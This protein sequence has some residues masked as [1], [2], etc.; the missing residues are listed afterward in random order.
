M[1]VGIAVGAMFAFH[2]ASDTRLPSRR[3]SFPGSRPRGAWS[4]P[5]PKICAPRFTREAGPCR[6]DDTR[7]FRRSSS[8]H[9]RSS[10]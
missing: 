10:L 2:P 9:R 4:W 8:T 7:F 3:W 6:P 5:R 1:Q